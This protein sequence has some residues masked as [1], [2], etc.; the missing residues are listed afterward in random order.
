MTRIPFGA[1]YVLCVWCVLKGDAAY[2]AMVM[3]TYGGARAL[4]MFPASWGVYRHRG[5]L[6]A[7]L[8]SPLF[9]VRRAQ[10]ILAVALTMFGAQVLLS[11]VLPAVHPVA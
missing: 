9:D 8:R 4:V 10:R 3:A 1:F 7:W 11:T 2:G 6:T 5:A